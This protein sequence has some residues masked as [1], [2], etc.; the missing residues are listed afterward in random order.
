MRIIYENDL[1]EI[2]K[3]NPNGEVALLLGAG[4][5]VSSDIPSGQDMIWDFKR[6]IYC[7]ENNI[8]EAK[9]KDILCEYNKDIIQNFFDNEKIAPSL[10][11]AN[12]YSYFF[13]RCFALP[14][15]RKN[16]ITE[17][18]RDKKPS[19]GYLCLGELIKQQ[20]ITRIFT[21]NFDELI[22]KGVHTLYPN[23]TI[24]KFSHTNITYD[25]FNP[26]I[27]TIINLHGDFKYDN[28]Q[29]TD[30]ELKSLELKVLERSKQLLQTG[31]LVVIGYAGNDNSV[32]SILE[33]GVSHNLFPNGIIWCKLKNSQL[34]ARVTKL[35]E[36]ACTRNFNS[37]VVEISGF[38]ILL[39]RI[40]RSKQIC[41]DIIEQM[42][43]GD[44]S[45]VSPIVFNKPK[46]VNIFLKTNGFLKL[47]MPATCLSFET[48]IKSW[49]ELREIT[50]DTLVIA[51]LY[52]GKI[53]SFSNRE[54][55]NNVFSSHIKSD[56]TE[57]SFNPPKFRGDSSVEMGLCYEIIEQDIINNKHLIKAG[58]RR[59]YNPNMLSSDGKY[60]EAIDVE[61]AFVN[62]DVCLTIY[63]TIEL[64]DKK[65]NKFER[66]KEINR[67]IGGRYNNRVYELLRIW[68]NI[69][70][71][72]KENAIKFSSQSYTLTFKALPFSC[73]GKKFRKSN[74]DELDSFVFEEPRLCFSEDRKSPSYVNQLKG[75]IA[76]SPLS[77][78]Y[79]SILQPDIQL[80]ILAPQENADKICNHL[81]NLNNKFEPKSDKG[82]LPTYLGF[83]T[84]FKRKLK[85]P[86]IDKPLFYSYNF[87]N[88]SSNYD[89]FYEFAKAYINS[90][91]QNAI[92][93][94]LIIYIP[95]KYE[96]YR[97]YKT[98]NTYFD[99]HDSLKLFC[100]DKG[101]RVQIIEDKSIV[102]TDKCKVMWGLSVSLFTKA[103]G[104]LWKPN[105]Y[106]PKTAFIGISYSLMRDGRHYLGCSQMFDSAGNGM[107]LH[108]KELNDPQFIGKN[109][110]MR[111]SDAFRIV[112]EL[113]NT[114][115]KFVTADKLERVVIHKTTP[116]TKNEIRGINQALI[117]IEDVELIQIQEFTNWRALLSDYKDIKQGASFA[118]SRG[119]VI[120]LDDD[121]F[122]LWTHGTI[123]SDE[124][125]GDKL[126][127]FKNGRGIPAPLLVR[128][129]QGHG[130]GDEIVKEILMLSKMNLNSG[131]SLYKVLPVTLDFAKTIARMVKQQNR[132]VNT[133]YDFRYFM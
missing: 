40:Y 28:I 130:S 49:K 122:L 102:N 17:K 99:L 125:L 39:Y 24:S 110:F 36:N 19:I 47:E 117:G 30:N 126:N 90:K 32:M 16:Y 7:R 129:F 115:S 106:N 26:T 119:T 60:Y 25:N 68:N 127:Y 108:L 116:F 72:K 35:M 10:Y 92:F 13:E 58:K 80:A 81:K 37:A 48:D 29:N 105:S 75:L 107:R 120:K 101:I 9:F 5:S 11:S 31:R 61:L 57:I 14:N 111:S 67:I 132:Q 34:N 94:I 43:D 76:N 12:E 44:L 131:D 100:A 41:N 62:S 86:N 89:A 124:L 27:P 83:E 4:A 71:D 113:R 46:E 118:L 88:Q 8:N 114:Y 20:N 3:A 38:D 63:P 96:K 128:R 93:D 103:N 79:S 82:F 50:K 18:V 77:D 70:F 121:S 66:Q 95:S 51:G 56:I 42:A 85:I 45:K 87:S 64:T 6:K 23:L 21:T 54:T 98:E 133:L 123:K 74:W 78:S 33:E 55:L 52:K 22:E 59:Y 97:E 84:I 1:I 2:F 91:L 73:G 104:E 109:P 15:E 69:F 53:I 65:L 112:S